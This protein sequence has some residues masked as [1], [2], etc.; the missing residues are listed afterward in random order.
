MYIDFLSAYDNQAQE[1]QEH[2]NCELLSP[3]K[4]TWAKDLAG[5]IRTH[6]RQFADVDMSHNLARRL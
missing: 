6:T 2:I 5:F 3:T 1:L 4:W